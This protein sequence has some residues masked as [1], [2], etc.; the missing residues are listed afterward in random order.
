MLRHRNPITS[1]ARFAIALSTR[2][3][4]AQMHQCAEFAEDFF[5]VKKIA[6]F[7]KNGISYADL[8]YRPGRVN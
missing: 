7:S 5:I 1:H 8:I 2:T 6:Y 4:S 3:R